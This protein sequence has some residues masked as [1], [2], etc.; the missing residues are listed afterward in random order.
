MNT[1]SKILDLSQAIS[2][3]SSWKKN[4]EKV[5]FTNG[6]FDILHLGHV[7]YLEKARNLGDRLIVGLNKDESIK[8]IK[9]STRPIVAEYPRARLMAALQFV[10]A[11]I[12]FGEDTPENLIRTIL[13]DILVKGDD[14]PLEKIIGA[15]IVISN[16]GKVQTVKLVEGFSTTNLIQKIKNY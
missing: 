12:L 5:V 13:P 8:R 7:D 1:A 14:Y 2:V 9:G 11:V 10:D 3:I 15:E 4:G 6:C 16:G